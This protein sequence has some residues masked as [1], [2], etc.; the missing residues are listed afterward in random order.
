MPPTISKDKGGPHGIYNH[1]KGKR[2]DQEH[3][4]DLSI[5]GNDHT[6]SILQQGSGD[7]RATV[8]L[9]GS[10][11]WNFDLTQSGASEQT[12]T[13]PHAM[14]DGSGVSGTCSAVGGCNLT[15]IQQ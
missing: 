13:L 14:S 8:V 1:Q 2:T 5:T 15:V 6:A 4:V 9:D 10:Q 11:P 7:K 12:Y 3:F